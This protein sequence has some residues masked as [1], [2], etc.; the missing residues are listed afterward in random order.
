[1]VV[2]L[3][4]ISFLTFVVFDILPARTRRPARGAQPDPG[5]A[6]AIRRRSG[7]TSDGASQY[8][9]DLDEPRLPLR[10]RLQLPDD[11][12]VA[13]ILDR[14]PATIALVAGGVI[15]GCSS[16]PR[17]HHPRRQARDADRPPRHGRR[18]RRDLRARLLV[19][20]V[21]LYLFSKDLGSSRSS[22]ARAPSEQRQQLRSRRVLE[23]LIMPWFVLAAVVRRGL[24][25]AAA[26]EPA[27]DHVGGLHP[28]RARQ[29]TLGA[30]SSSS[31]TRRSAITPIVTIL[32]LDLGIL[33][34]GAILTETVF[35]IPGIGRLAFD[36]IESATW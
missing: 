15:C 21:S 34:G 27:R 17:R 1:M 18:A 8:V 33:L 31:S 11:V 10:L 4:V 12:A 16:G 13:Q 14:L 7:S 30:A 2:L 26:R 20:L 5:A 24:R 3:L 29:G 32:G 19:G 36:A 6:G 9:N 28:H 25:A 22:R 23:S 35:N